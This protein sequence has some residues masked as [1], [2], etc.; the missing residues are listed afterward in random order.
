MYVENTDFKLNMSLI[1]NTLPVVNKVK[2][3]VV[4]GELISD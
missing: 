3:L 4:V 1:S 2:D